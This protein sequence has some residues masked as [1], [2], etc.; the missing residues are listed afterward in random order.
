ML[1]VGPAGYCPGMRRFVAGWRF[2]SVAPVVVDRLIVLGLMFVGVAQAWPGYVPDPEMLYQVDWPTYAGPVAFAIVAPLPLLIRR[3]HPLLMFGS[4]IVAFAATTFL[5]REVSSPAFA[6]F[7]GAY[8]IGRYAPARDLSIGAMVVAIGIATVATIRGD[9]LSTWFAAM[10]AIFVGL[11]LVGDT[12]QARELRAEQLEERAARHEVEQRA[13]VAQA[14]TDERSRIARELHD[15]I[16]HNVSVMVVQAAAAQR[17]MDDDPGQAR[18]SLATIEST[19]RE[20]LTEMRR[21]LGVLRAGEPR[22]LADPGGSSPQPSLRR[23]PQL[24]EEMRS[25]GL[26]VELSVE[27]T[28]RDVPPGVDLSA[29]RVVQEA[30]TNALRHA[31]GTATRVVVRYEPDAL[32]LE[33]V[34]AGRANASGQTTIVA[35]A[36][37]HGLAGMRERVALV[38]GELE[39]G[40]RPEGGFRVRARLPVDAA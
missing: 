14:A 28:P 39:A 30:L 20:A 27:G 34:D 23:L 32:D 25:S 2:P 35:S 38:R 5:S 37:G 36:G 17:V 6:V 3:S 24:V 31:G 22:P 15:V 13:S 10:I 29:Y 8:S 40:P 19:G 18:A 21:L 11:W 12:A 9:G 7:L 16:A 33:I 1:R 26:P 4:C